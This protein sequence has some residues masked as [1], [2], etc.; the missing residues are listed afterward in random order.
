MSSSAVPSSLQTAGAP[1][2]LSRWVATLDEPWT[3][4]EQCDRGDWLIW[5]AAVEGVPVA[6]LVDAAAA[7]AERAVAAV[8]TGRGPLAEAIAAAR[9]RASAEACAAAA[10]RCQQMAAGERPQSYRTAGPARY[11]R[12]AT[13]AAHAARAAEGLLLSEA[14]AGGER[15]AEG[16]ERAAAVGAGA[17]I[18][19]PTKHRGPAR[20]PL[21]A[22]ADDPMAEWLRYAVDAAAQA[23]VD[24]VRALPRHPAADRSLGTVEEE[25]SEIV[26]ELLDPIREALRQGGD[27]F[28]ARLTW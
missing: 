1:A 4:W 25:L 26:F 21:D 22:P 6:A 17:M 10:E 15:D 14:R 11:A 5:L 9:P 18:I 12:A 3:A 23:A 8:E 24:A 2:A 27:A 7:C 19:V 13:A 28:A 20:L 16:R